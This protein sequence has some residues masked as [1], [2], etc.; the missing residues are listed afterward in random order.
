MLLV[1]RLIV[2]AMMYRG[3]M[4]TAEIYSAVRSQAKR[5]RVKL[6]PYWHSTVRNTLQRHCRGNTKY[7]KPHYFKHVKRGTWECRV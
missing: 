7:R 3:E 1:D 6:S 2:P 4:T 5:E